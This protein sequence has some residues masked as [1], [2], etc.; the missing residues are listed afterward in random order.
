MSNN[1]YHT[2]YTNY[3]NTPITNTGSGGSGAVSYNTMNGLLPNPVPAINMTDFGNFHC[4]ILNFK[5]FKAQNGFIVE[6]GT[7]ISY[8]DMANGMRVPKKD[9]YIIDD[10]QNMGEIITQILSLHL[11]AKE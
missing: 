2:N 9:L 4:S 1:S 10:I 6:V 5:L 7:D 8:V 3:T 11:L